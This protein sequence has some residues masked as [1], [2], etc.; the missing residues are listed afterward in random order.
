MA[1]LP[2]CLPACLLACASGLACRLALLLAL[3]VGS[4]F[5]LSLNH[6]S[7]LGTPVGVEGFFLFL[8]VSTAFSARADC[9]LIGLA[10]LVIY[11]ESVSCML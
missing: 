3:G 8:Y 7:P 11:A 10:F 6:S 2:G 9:H 5:V 1:C 4:A